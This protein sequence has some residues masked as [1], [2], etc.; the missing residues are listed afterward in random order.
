MTHH[1]PDR[2]TVLRL[3][4]ERR[5]DWTARFG[6]SVVGLIGSVGRGTAGENSDVDLLADVAGAPS[7]F[8]LEKLQR[9]ISD[10]LGCKVDVIL[11]SALAPHWRSFAEA[12]LVAA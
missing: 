2:E 9:E 8:D 3:V 11:R 4:R 10:A 7:L 6:I 5:Q 12:E 1:L